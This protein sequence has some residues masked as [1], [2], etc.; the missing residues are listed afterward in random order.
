MNVRLGCVR[1]G[2]VVFAERKVRHC[3]S[4]SRLSFFPRTGKEKNRA[5]RLCVSSWLQRSYSAS[6]FR[7]APPCPCPTPFY[8]PFAPPLHRSLPPLSPPCSTAWSRLLAPPRLLFAPCSAH[9]HLLFRQALRLRGACHLLGSWSALLAFCFGRILSRPT[10]WSGRQGRLR[11]VGCVVEELRCRRREREAGA[12][13]QGR[14]QD[15]RGGYGGRDRIRRLP[16]WR[17]GS[18]S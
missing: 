8:S 12:G 1:Y 17:R 5:V 9:S 6:S 10:M 16:G 3:Q 14:R 15:A 2:E 18:E 13:E 11:P 7:S 4:K